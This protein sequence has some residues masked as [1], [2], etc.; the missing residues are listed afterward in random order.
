MPTAANDHDRQHPERQKPAATT[1]GP[2]QIR[3]NEEG[4]APE[5]QIAQERQQSTGQGMGQS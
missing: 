4:G 3:E 5:R 2:P 1:D